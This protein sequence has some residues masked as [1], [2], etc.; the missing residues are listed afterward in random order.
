MADTAP[1]PITR[2]V[3]DSDDRAA[4][5]RVMDS[6]FLVQG[7]EVAAFEHEL[8]E[9]VG[10]PHAVAMSSCTAALHVSL[11]ALGVGRGDLVLV[12]PY[13]WVAT[14]NVIELC[15][16]TPVFVDVDP[17]TMN[18]SADQLVRQ[19]SALADAGLSHRVRAVMPVHTFGNPLGIPEVIEVASDRAV[20]VVEDA[21]CALGAT[22]AGR[23][24]GTIGEVGCYSFHPRKVITTGE[25][26]MLVT[27]DERIADFARA[28]RNHGQSRVGD[29]VA[30]TMAGANLRLTDVQ[31]ALGRA[32][33][34]K[35]LMLCETRAALAARYDEE[36]PRLGLVPQRR[37]STA[38]VQ[39]YVA[40]VPAGR[41][42]A[43]VI[44][45]LRSRGVE[46]TVG[47]NAI[48]FLDHYASTY[49]LRPDQLPVTYELAERA[50]T[51]PLY[52][53]MTAEDQAR[54][55]AAV[56]EVLR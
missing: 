15:G 44:D 31:G 9:L 38:V 8:A 41:S 52:P 35:L 39:S 1:I 54:V 25:G 33:L 11:L 23:H 29:R 43:A 18:M 27:R 42:G 46:A 55:V 28:F 49:G 2:P 45:G 56:A 24:A 50:V 12:A 47:T 51:L 26:G 7:P 20:P 4:I 14:A 5:D 30:V 34:V 37:S 17:E 10:A 22:A 16:A 6:G 21:A 13:S 53:A 40:L 3:L 32:Q 36:L 19:L 48:P